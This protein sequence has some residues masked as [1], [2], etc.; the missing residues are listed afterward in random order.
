[1]RFQRNQILLILL[2][3]ISF[4][5]YVAGCTHKEEV[6]PAQASGT[7]TYS[8]GDA[9]M[10]PGLET[11]GDTTQWKLDQVHCSVLWSGAYLGATGLLTGRF[12]SFG[13]NN[14]TPALQTYDSSSGQPLPDTSWAFYENEPAKT[15]FTGYVQINTS[16]TGEPARDSGCNISALHTIKI[17]PGEQNL[18]DSNIALIQTTSVTF[19]PNGSDYIVNANLTWRGGMAT[20][21][22]A[23]VTGKLVF[24]P[25][26]WATEGTSTFGVFGLQLTFQFNCSDWGITS[27]NIGQ[28]ITI[29]ANMNFN[30]K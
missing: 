7:T 12:N 22:T 19:D 24:I 14:V 11:A 17:I 27:T 3:F 9:I 29:Q 26:N 25:E 21:F 23:P 13:L 20:P 1:M 28:E 2:I 4:Y 10:L 8:H 16:N 5:G 30:N 18:S 15:Y 6:L